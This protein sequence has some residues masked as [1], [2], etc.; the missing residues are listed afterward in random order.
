MT[1]GGPRVV[2]DVAGAHMGGAARFLRELDGWLARS[3]RCDVE[4]LGRGRSLTA[5]WLVGR[6]RAA[7][8]ASALVAVNNVAFLRPGARSTVLLRNALHFLNPAERRALA[9]AVTPG[10]RAQSIVVRAA[11]RR[12]DRVV[13]PT[14]T[15]AERVLAHLPVLTGRLVVRPHPLTPPAPGHVEP[16]TVLCPVLFAGYKQMGRH[17][18]LLLA[19]MTG[20]DLPDLRVLVTAEPAE[21]DEGLRADSRL[22]LLGRLSAAELDAVTASAQVLYYPTLVES[23]GYPLAE[24]R[25]AG[26]PVLAPVGGTARD[27]AGASWEPY[28]EGDVASLRA[29]L[30]RA[31]TRTSRPDPGPFDPDAYFP[32][33]L[34]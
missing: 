10:L 34:S 1:G 11:A 32:W 4:V 7:S 23:F 30:V 27:L 9:E 13:V 12:A 16:G 29:A 8:R 25:A 26:R 21:V 3:G 31:L 19:A 14:T 24:A 15:M 28:D 33:L 6:E 5:G 20:P 22:V 17:L 18:G 2:V